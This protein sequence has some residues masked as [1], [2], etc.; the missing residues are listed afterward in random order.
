[1]PFG[2]LSFPALTAGRQAAQ[3]QKHPLI[4]RGHAER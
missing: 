3:A 2:R 1:M 4:Q